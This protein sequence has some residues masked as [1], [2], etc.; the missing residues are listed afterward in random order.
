[1]SASRSGSRPTGTSRRRSTP[2]RVARRSTPAWSPSTERG[3]RPAATSAATG[4]RSRGSPASSSTRRPP[5]HWPTACAAADFA[6]R[7]VEDKP[8]TRRP[9]APFMTSTLQQEA[10]RKLRMTAQTAMRVAQRLYENGHITYMRTDSTTL[11]ESALNAARSQAREIYGPEYVPDVPR[12]YERKVKNAQEAHEAI[13]PSG[14]SFRTPG[15]AR[16]RGQPGRARALRPDLEA[17]RRLADDRRPRPDGHRP[18]RRDVHRRPGRGVL[19]QPARS[20]RSAAS[21]RPTRRAGT[22]TAAA[23]TTATSASGGCR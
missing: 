3:S 5:S 8:Y 21:S 13:R 15:A 11:S 18:A 6:V 22:T 12:R 19:H 2:R 16:R 1:M 10:A 7:S 17:H 23:A 14:D 9:A 20:S 4:S